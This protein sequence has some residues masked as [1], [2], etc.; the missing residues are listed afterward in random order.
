MIKPVK[1]K[2]LKDYKLLINFSNGET[3]VYDASHLLKYEIFEKLKNKDFFATAKIDC[4]SVVWN[5]ELDIAPEELY[6][7]GTPYIK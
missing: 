1:V 7:T 3:K 4:G 2:Y 6:T 5:N